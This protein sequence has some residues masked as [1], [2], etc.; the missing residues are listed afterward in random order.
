M[1]RNNVITYRMA[2]DEVE[3]LGRMSKLLPGVNRSQVIR[4]ALLLLRT[5]ASESLQRDIMKKSWV[6]SFDRYYKILQL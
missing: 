6:R 2:D 1:A 5:A 4:T 3:Y